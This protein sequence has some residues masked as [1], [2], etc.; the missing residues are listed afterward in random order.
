LL[1]AHRLTRFLLGRSKGSSGQCVLDEVGGAPGA[2]LGAGGGLQ[3]P[4]AGDTFGIG[5][6]VVQRRAEDL[7]R[8]VGGVQAVG[9]AVPRAGRRS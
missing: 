3:L 2:S 6:E 1:R 5:D 8:G 7:G 9:D 4:G